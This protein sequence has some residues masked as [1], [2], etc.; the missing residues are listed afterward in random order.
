MNILVNLKHNDITVANMELS[1]ANGSI[2]RYKCIKPELM[3]YL[4]E[5]TLKELNQWW[6]YRAIPDNRDNLREIL[7]DS[8]CETAMLYLLKNLALS[9]PV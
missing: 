3:P 2:L 1:D 6:S 9:L 7:S 5:M 4:R 8:E